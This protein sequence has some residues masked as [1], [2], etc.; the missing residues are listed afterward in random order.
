ML[1]RLGQLHARRRANQ[2]RDADGRFQIRDAPA[3]RRG[4]NV[5]AVRGACDRSFFDD[6]DEELETVGIDAHACDKRWLV[7]KYVTGHTRANYCVA[8]GGDV[9]AAL[10]ASA[11]S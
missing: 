2:E 11:I 4:R 10:F 8:S 5:T 9:D 7:A 1:P 6:R 3:Q